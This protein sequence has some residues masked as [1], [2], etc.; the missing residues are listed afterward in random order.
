[1]WLQS[2]T[3]ENTRWCPAYCE[4]EVT[5]KILF[6]TSVLTVILFWIVMPRENCSVLGC[7]TCT[8]TKEVQLEYTCRNYQWQNTRPIRNGQQITSRREVNE[9]YK[10]QIHLHH[11]PSCFKMCREGF[12]WLPFSKSEGPPL[13][14]PLIGTNFHNQSPSTSYVF[15]KQRFVSLKY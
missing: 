6:F 10:K 4:R 3:R 2:C 8:R 13:L 1:M 12:T 9:E 5:V 14:Q 7:G 15:L 11:P